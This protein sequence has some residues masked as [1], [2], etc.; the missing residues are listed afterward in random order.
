[1]I[2]TDTKH[3]IYLAARATMREWYGE[4]MERQASCLYWNQ[5]SMR[6]LAIRGYTPL[7]HAGTLMWRIVPD[8]LDDGRMATH[9]GYEW[10]PDDPFSIAATSAGLLP[11]VHV[12]TM[13]KETGDLV[14]FSTGYFPTDAKKHGLK[15][16]TEPPPLYIFGEPPTDAHYKATPEAT[17]YMWRFILEKL[18]DAPQELIE[19]QLA[20]I[21]A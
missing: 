19:K 15:W 2:P 1:M 6:E 12:W 14:D 18:C 5:C 11:E 10:S 17:R 3:E 21:P 16:G 4:R 20:L 7:M 8:V 13:V 9:F